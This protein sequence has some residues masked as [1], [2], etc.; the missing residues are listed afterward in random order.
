MKRKEPVICR[1]FRRMVKQKSVMD[2]YD[3]NRLSIKA[4]YSITEIRM[5]F[6]IC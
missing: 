5:P 3:V 1:K 2:Y 4:K 6:K